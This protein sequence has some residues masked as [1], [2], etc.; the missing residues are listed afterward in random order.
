MDEKEITWQAPE[1]LYREKDVSWYWLSIILTALLALI[2]LWQR[3]FLFLI[4]LIIAEMMIIF[5]GKEYPKNIEFKINN[6]GIYIGSIK[7]YPY[8][9]L[10]GY[11]IME[12]N[13]YASELILRTRNRFNPFVKILVANDDIPEIKKFLQ[14]HLNEVEYDESLNDRISK[15]IG[16]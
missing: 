5:W 2:S 9:D 11:H 15:I 16:F 13:D 14:N 1:Y 12:E 4:F 10:E 8:E 7:Y 3:N 6:K